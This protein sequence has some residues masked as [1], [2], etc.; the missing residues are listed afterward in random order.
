M[1]SA[2]LFKNKAPIATTMKV[3]LVAA[4]FSLALATPRLQLSEEWHQWKSE[5]GKSY[6]S[7]REELER[8]LVWQSNLKYIEAHNQNAH[9]LG[10]SLKMNH[11]GDLVSSECKHASLNH[12][13]IGLA[14]KLSICCQSILYVPVCNQT[15]C[16]HSS[17]NKCLYFHLYLLSPLSLSIFSSE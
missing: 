12:S 15:T 9:I 2:F 6:L 10:F 5:H 16:M 13:I 1:V 8:H 14:R 4:L 3:L 17:R 11:F 7:E